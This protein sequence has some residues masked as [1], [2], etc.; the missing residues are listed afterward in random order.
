MQAI[1]VHEFGDPSVLKLDE[2]PD[3]IPAAGQVVVRLHA[4]GRFDIG[5]PPYD[6]IVEAPLPHLHSTS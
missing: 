1:R 3:P 4:I 6:D 2:V 5:C